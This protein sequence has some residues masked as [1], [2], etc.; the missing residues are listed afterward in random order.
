MTAERGR[1]EGASLAL[2][3]LGDEGGDFKPTTMPFLRNGLGSSNT[4][5]VCVPP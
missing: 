3:T 5:N 1:E 4:V 2:E